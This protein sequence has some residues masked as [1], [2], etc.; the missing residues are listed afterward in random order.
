MGIDLAEYADKLGP[1]TVDALL[2]YLDP[3][4]KT[5]G[6]MGKSML[7]ACPGITPRAAALRGTRLRKK[8]HYLPCVGAILSQTADWD[9][10]V[11][12]LAQV[13]QGTYEVETIVQ[14]TDKG[15]VV[16]SEETITRRPSASDV[17]KAIDIANRLDGTYE[18]RPGE[19]LGMS[20]TFREL[21]KRLMPSGVPNRH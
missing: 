14:H 20:P 1:E 12:R 21:A 7:D 6:N 11:E 3:E 13:M 2:R 16:T 4:S 8:Q 18:T 5:Y 15:G 17:L 19:S 9:V 10:R